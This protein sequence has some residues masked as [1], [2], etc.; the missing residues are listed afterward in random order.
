MINSILYVLSFLL[1]L[2][3]LFKWASNNKQLEAYFAKQ[4]KVIAKNHGIFKADSTYNELLKIH[5]VGFGSVPNTYKSRETFKNITN[6]QSSITNCNEWSP[7]KNPAILRPYNESD[8]NNRGSTDKQIHDKINGANIN[9]EAI[10]REK[11]SRE[12]SIINR[13]LPEYTADISAILTPENINIL[14]AI[15]S[16][17]IPVSATV[18]DIIPWINDP[19]N[20][21]FI[22][23]DDKKNIL[24][25]NNGPWIKLYTQIQSVKLKFNTAVYSELKETD[26]VRQYSKSYLQVAN[27]TRPNVN[28][29]NSIPVNRKLL[30]IDAKRRHKL[31]MD[32]DTKILT[33]DEYKN[34]WSWVD[35]VGKQLTVPSDFNIISNADTIRDS[36]TRT[37]MDILT[38]YDPTQFGCQRIYQECSNRSIPE[39]SSINT[40]AEY[41]KFLDKLLDA[42]A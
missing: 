3:Y 34:K 30:N 13:K 23:D 29:S 36:Q 35:K 33:P 10:I 16:Y 20:T 17:V 2:Y 18:T 19:M 28:N 27:P 5:R 11:Q 37:V 21:H 42:K 39:L 31:A 9:K 22:T 25:A 8:T 7:R 15:P 14:R 6:Q 1:I 12:T 24:T 4:K 32:L 38:D 40:P 41:N 26:T